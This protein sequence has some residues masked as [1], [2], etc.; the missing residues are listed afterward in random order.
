MG[1]SVRTICKK[2]PLALDRLTE[3]LVENSLLMLPD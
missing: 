3:L 2:L 1:V